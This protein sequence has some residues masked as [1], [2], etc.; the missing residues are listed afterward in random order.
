MQTQN[1]ILDDMEKKLITRAMEQAHQ[2]KTRAAEILGI[3]TSSLYYK[4]D[5]YGLE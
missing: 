5:K 3:K 1:K 2:V 4:L